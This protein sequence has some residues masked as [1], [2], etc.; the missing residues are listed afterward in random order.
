M[1]RN[2]GAAIGAIVLFSSLFIFGLSIA[3]SASVSVG[4]SFNFSSPQEV[5]YTPTGAF[6]VP[7]AG[8]DLFFYDGFWWTI[9]ENYWYRA[10]AY[11]GNWYRVGARYVP[12]AVYRIH[13]TPNYRVY[14]GK[15]VD[16]HISYSKWKSHGWH[17][18]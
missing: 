18:R 8:L 2:L 3:S 15:R 13:R 6:F 17:N 9:R 1:N 4:V 16:R 10:R 7:N 5:V 14:Y 12:Y 11:N